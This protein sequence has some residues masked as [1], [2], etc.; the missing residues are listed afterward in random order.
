MTDARPT[1]WV[2]LRGLAREVGHWGDFAAR[3]AAAQPAARVVT[4]DTPGNG[5]RRHDPVPSRIEGTMEAVRADLEALV[6]TA[7][8]GPTYVF[9]MSMGGMI[10]VAWAAAHGDELAGIVVGNSSL[11]GLSP[12]WRRLRPGIWPTMA[13]SGASRTPARRE[14]AALAMVSNDPAIRAANL[15][16]WI[17]I[18]TSRPL[19][20]RS[21]RAQ[22][23]AAARFRAPRSPL[24]APLLV[25]GSEGDRMVHQSCSRAIASHYGAPLVVHPTAGHDHALDAPDWTIERLVGF[26]GGR[27]VRA[28]GGA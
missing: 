8:R 11:G 20:V 24:G 12:F 4:I 21:A 3:L 16:G 15:P 1:T 9:A 18:A 25:I 27:A 28:A 2:L 26:A 7:T 10:A 14:A 6:P 13:A 19:P 17:E 23:L 22:L 5:A